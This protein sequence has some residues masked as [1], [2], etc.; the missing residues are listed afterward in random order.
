MKKRWVVSG[1]CAA[2]VA[3]A[4]SSGSGSTGGTGGTGGMF[5][6]KSQV[7]FPP[8]SEFSQDVEI[9]LFSVP[10]ACS[11]IASGMPTSTRDF[12]S[13]F[14]EIKS[15]TPVG[16]GKKTVIIPDGVSLTGPDRAS[17]L[18]AG[19]RDCRSRYGGFATGT[20]DITA[21]DMSHVAGTFT[22]HWESGWPY[23]ATFGKGDFSGSFDA[24]ACDRMGHPIDGVHCT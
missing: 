20:L 2:S 23:G 17:A 6:I 14:I 13:L 19:D 21:I 10:N 16:P 5:V 12:D 4:C 15:T 22:L 18:Y 3:A 11:L 8:Q 7:Y 24:P 1:L 9:Y